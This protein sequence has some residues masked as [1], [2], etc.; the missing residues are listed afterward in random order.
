[1]ASE[2]NIVSS[3]D[4]R[5]HRPTLDLS[6]SRFSF[7]K[8]SG[9]LSDGGVWEDVTQSFRK[10][11]TEMEIG[12]LIHLDSFNLHAAMS[13][14]EL[15]DPKMDIGFDK[16]KN[17]D[18]I[19][20]PSHLS[21]LQVINIMDELLACQMSWFDAHTLPQTVFACVYTQR[22][23]QIPRFELFAFIQLQLAVM[24]SVL[25]L[26]LEEKVAD[27]EDFIASTY[28]FNI[29]P[30]SDPPEDD[31]RH[32]RKLVE[33]VYDRPVEDTDVA[34]SLA[35][36]ITLRVIV[37]GQ[38]YRVV[39]CLSGFSFEHSLTDAPKLL[40]ELQELVTEWNACVHRREVD[41][42][43]IHLI[44]DPSINRH[45]MTSSPPRTASLFDVDSA[46]RY[47]RRLV[48]EWTELVKL[49]TVALPPDSSLQSAKDSRRY[50]L[51][52]AMHSIS[53]FLSR[54]DPTTVTRS[55]MSRIMVPEFASCLFTRRN[56]EFKR[57]MATDMGLTHSMMTLELLSMLV[58]AKG[59]IVDIFKCLCRNR[60]RQRRQVL[61]NLRWWDHF[62]YV[63][64]S[65]SD[66]EADPEER[67]EREMLSSGDVHS[68]EEN[69]NTSERAPQDEPRKKG[70]AIEALFGAKNPVQTIAYELSARL[71][72]HHWL[73]G[74]ECE[75]YEQYE[76]AAVFFY[77]GYVLTTMSNATTSLAEK[78]EEGASLH[79]VRF[80]LYTMD[81]ARLWMCRATHAALEAFSRDT[82]IGYTCRRANRRSEA[83][84]GMF[85]SEA[86][87]YEQRFG[88]VKGLLNGPV[89]ADYEAFLAFRKA[90]E[91]SLMSGKEGADLTLL[92]IEDAANGY[93]VARRTLE[94]A[95][96]TAQKCSA[97]DLSEE[98][99]QIARVA[100][101]NSL[102]LSQLLRSMR[103]SQDEKRSYG[104]DLKFIRHRHFPVIDI[105]VL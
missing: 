74:F 23:Y 6:V 50:S 10:A 49:E 27:D 40:R 100:V 20:L 72:I 93:V 84:T 30:R 71:M 9:N 17:V 82:R 87:W 68:H 54:L 73:L 103:S 88:V 46:L 45:L 91:D 41:K 39:Q 86:L 43:L 1:M 104:V 59:G 97:N 21:D 47:L 105:T 83:G 52:V 81:E 11:K 15:M 57:L 95:K 33:K 61:R 38:L 102:T 5:D 22:M 75:L 29:R 12:E 78:S 64:G 67:L 70:D 85:G 69:C 37:Q 42:E 99:M 60:S 35:D 28:G 79:S 48:L 34:K 58:P 18:D 2:D 89:Y 98:I 25:N 14:I 66:P 76:Y 96:K 65:K 16:T 55:L 3:D 80:A 56:A 77:V 26:V 44:F 51:Q 92:L 19:V 8:K 13:A 24:D 36:A 53:L 7:P 31:F 90:H 32:L 62:A 63:S 4:R 101:E 94:R